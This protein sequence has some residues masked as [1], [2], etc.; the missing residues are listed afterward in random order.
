[1]DKSISRW[2]GLGGRW[3]NCGLPNYVTMDRNF[4]NGCEIQDACDGRSKFMIRLKLVKGATENAALESQ[5]PGCLHG[6]RVMK[7][8]VQPWANSGRV[9]SA[10]SYFASVPCTLA[11]M[12]MVLRF[13]GVVKTATK[14]F[15]KRTYRQL[16]YH[17]KVTTKEY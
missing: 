11:L 2:Y 9:V 17:R 12:G 10:D 7:F 6:T 4:K 8:L 1:M 13:I 15:H 5:D 14:E 3:I 16:S